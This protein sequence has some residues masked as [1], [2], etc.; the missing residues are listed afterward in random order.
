MNYN[1]ENKRILVAEDQPANYL[2]I[3]KILNPTHVSLIHVNDGQ[4]AVEKIKEDSN[5]DLVLMDIYMPEKDGF[6]AADEIK[7]LRPDL[8]IIAQ[9]YLSS[10]IDENKLKKAAF[11]ALIKKPI[12]INKLLVVVDQFLSLET[13]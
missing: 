1:W 2:F 12:N 10:D 6:Q 9:T 4:E 11:S 8:P 13:A 5:I 3:E 7:K